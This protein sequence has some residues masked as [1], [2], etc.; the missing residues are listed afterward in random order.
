V[1]NYA[2]LLLPSPQSGRVMDHHLQ[3][4]GCGYWYGGE[5]Y[6]YGPCQVKQQ[7]AD[8]RFITFGQHPCDEP[9]VT[10]GSD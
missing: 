5:D 7:R 10:E 1:S 3:C 2:Y 4:K 9:E 8:A 6:G